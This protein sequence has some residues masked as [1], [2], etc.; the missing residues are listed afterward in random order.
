MA[1]ERGALLL[2]AFSDPI[3]I[4]PLVDA[5]DVSETDQREVLGKRFLGTLS[6]LSLDDVHGL[7]NHVIFVTTCDQ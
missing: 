1:G 5:S 4:A 2:L 7:S 3:T 6:V